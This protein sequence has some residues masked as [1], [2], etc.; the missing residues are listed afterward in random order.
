MG[1]PKYRAD[2]GPFYSS[3]TGGGQ[4]RSSDEVLD[5]YYKDLSRVKT[6]PQEEERL[7]F[8]QYRAARARIL[9]Y[10][11]AHPGGKSLFIS[12]QRAK[13]KTIREQLVE[14]CLKLVF[15]LARRYWMDQD[16]STLKALIS[17]GNVGL[18]EAVEKFDPARGTK[19]SSYASFWI[20]MYVRN[21]LTSLKDVVAPTSREKKLRMQ[22]AATRSAAEGDSETHPP[23]H[24]KFGKNTYVD[25]ST[26]QE[27]DLLGIDSHPPEGDSIGD[28]SELF[29]RWFRFLT[30]R[31][32]FVLRAYYGMLN[33]EEGIKL[34]QI[35]SHLGL[36]SERVRQVKVDALA[37]LKRWM[38]HD[39]VTSCSDVL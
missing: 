33:G 26:M 18:L 16:F 8:E 4:A 6:L 5:V 3:R 1:A 27:S 38:E 28:A 23:A 36:S 39:G 30:V 14:S 35:S 22:S 20:L 34:R 25:I 2:L 29:Q 19:F 17:A 11:T 10:D 37:K 12:Y 31:E 15:S 21:E 24:S 32:Q 9:Q 7:L 13:N